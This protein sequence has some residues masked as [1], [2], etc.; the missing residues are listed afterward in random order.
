MYKSGKISF[1]TLSAN[2]ESY[3]LAKSETGHAE[4]PQVSDWQKNKFQ[5]KESLEINA[6]IACTTVQ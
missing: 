6:A 5:L 2:L 1:E 4:I 3:K